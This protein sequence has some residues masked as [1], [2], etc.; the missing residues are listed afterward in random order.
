MPLHWR[1]DRSDGCGES[2]VAAQHVHEAGSEDPARSDA[3]VAHRR[4]KLVMT[5]QRLDQTDIRAACSARF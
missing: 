5:K 4:I 3:R 1:R 2:R